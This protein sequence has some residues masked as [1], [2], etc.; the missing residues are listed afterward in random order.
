MIV[1]ELGDVA[2]NIHVGNAHHQR[3]QHDGGVQGYSAGQAVLTVPAFFGVAHL[4]HVHNLTVHQ[5]VAMAQAVCMVR[6]CQQ[7]ML[8]AIGKLLVHSVVDPE[9]VY[10]L[11]RDEV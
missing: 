10:D 6:A 3:A 4:H 11:F 9:L 1:I 8:L 2:S 5:G 7:Q